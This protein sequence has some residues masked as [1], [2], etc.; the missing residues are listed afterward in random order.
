MDMLLLE[1][2]EAPIEDI[3]H[4]G[5]WERSSSFRHEQDRKLL[6]NPKAIKKITAMW[7]K[8][9][10]DFNIYLVNNAE[11]NRHTEVGLVDRQWLDQN[12]PNTSGSINVNPD[13]INVI[14]TNNKGDERVPMTGWIMAH[15]LGH[16]FYRYTGRDQFQDLHDAAEELRASAVMSM[17]MLFNARIKEG[18]YFDARDDRLMTRFYE[19][20]GTF[21]S[22]RDGNIRNE[23]EFI[24]ECFAQYLLTGKVKFNPIPD[25]IKDGR[26]FLFNK[27][28]ETD[29]NYY[30]FGL[31]DVAETIGYRFSDLLGRAVGKILVM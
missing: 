30:N 5:D 3:T 6:T 10:Q 9:E 15:R 1:L 2:M 20:I 21:R 31:E 27:G 8:T 29:N 23:G 17:N 7:S 28:S 11:A 19:A 16:A 12:M 4:L 24:H 13:A 18:R 26:S 25:R 22:A 14:F